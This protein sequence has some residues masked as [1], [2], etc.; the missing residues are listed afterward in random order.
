MHLLTRLQDFKSSY[1]VKTESFFFK[2]KT[3]EMNT[4][5]NMCLKTVKMKATQSCPTLCN[6]MGYTV[7]GILQ[8]RIQSGQPFPSPG[9]L[10]NPGIK[11]RSPT[12][13]EN[14]LPAEPS[15][16]PKNTVGSLSLLR[17]IFPTQESNWGLLHCRQI[18]YQ[19]SYQGSQSSL[20]LIT[21]SEEKH[22]D[23]SVMNAVN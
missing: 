21:S 20:L 6:P 12:L 5:F 2:M 11:C 18:L 4:H 19:L 16:K 14:S 22:H 1:S 10:P 9:D 17:Q 15:G 8:V 3:I 7:H 23:H 13:Q